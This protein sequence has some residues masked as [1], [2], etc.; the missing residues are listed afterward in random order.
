MGGEYGIKVVLA[1]DGEFL[2]GFE[3]VFFGLGEELGPV[4][5]CWKADGLADQL[6]LVG[7]GVSLEERDAVVEELGDDA[8]DRPYVYLPLVF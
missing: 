6:K 7:L 8:A 5:F 2:D 3:D 1:V 4:L